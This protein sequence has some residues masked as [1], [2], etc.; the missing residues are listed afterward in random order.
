M[1]TNMTSQEKHKNKEMYSNS[2]KHINCLSGSK[3]IRNKTPAGHNSDISGERT[4]QKKKKR[5]KEITNTICSTTKIFYPKI[6][7]YST[8]TGDNM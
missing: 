6:F 7:I 4:R 5:L 8:R 2:L 1:M 3:L